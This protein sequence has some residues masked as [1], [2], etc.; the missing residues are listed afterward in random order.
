MLAK[1][2]AVVLVWFN[3]SA[4]ACIIAPAATAVGPNQPLLP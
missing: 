4:N 1:P 3:T 2:A